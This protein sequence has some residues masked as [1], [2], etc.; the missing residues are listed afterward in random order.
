MTYTME[1]FKRDYIK[2]HFAQL[3]SQE[4]RQALER[5][6]SEHLREVL[7]LLPPEEL[8]GVQSPEQ[9]REYLDRQSTGHPTKR[10]TAR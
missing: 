8:L 6:S 3:T 7:Q 10:R 4:Q 1:D 9:I 5:L 2:E